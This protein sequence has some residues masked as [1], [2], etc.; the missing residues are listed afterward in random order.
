MRKRSSQELT[1]AA[2]K[3]GQ[4]H[5]RRHPPP[6]K[7]WRDLSRIEKAGVVLVIAFVVLVVLSPL[8]GRAT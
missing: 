7:R 6:E 2:I 3:A 1:D 4:E 8:L 5:R